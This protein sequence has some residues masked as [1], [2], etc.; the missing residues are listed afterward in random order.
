MAPLNKL[1]EV[2]ESYRVATES[3]SYWAP[4]I[5][6]ATELTLR[7]RIRKIKYTT[8]RY[9]GGNYTAA[10]AKA[11]KLETTTNI[12]DISLNEALDN[13]YTLT[14]TLKETGLWGAWY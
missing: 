5:P 11:D 6:P 7:T 4:A 8:T 1:K 2:I 3:Q 13:L 9:E 10:R 12:T 14:A